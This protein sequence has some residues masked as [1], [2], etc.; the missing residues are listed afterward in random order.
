MNRLKAMNGRH[1][2]NK[3][4]KPLNTPHQPPEPGSGPSAGSSSSPNSGL[5]DGVSQPQ[6]AVHPAA[7]TSSPPVPQPSRV[8][9]VGGGENTRAAVLE[10]L[11]LLTAAPPSRLSAGGANSVSPSP[12]ALDCYPTVR[13]AMEHVAS[14]RP[15]IAL[16][17]LTSFDGLSLRNVR[18]LHALLPDLRILTIAPTVEQ[19]QPLLSLMAGASGCLLKPL[20]VPQLA[21]SIFHAMDGRL[22]L[23]APD[24]RALLNWMHALGSRT[25]RKTLTLQE[26]RVLQLLAQG[27]SY[28]EISA[29][30]GIS[31]HTVHAHAVNAFRKLGAHGRNDAVRKLLRLPPGDLA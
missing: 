14:H 15:A 25:C 16:V 9:L 19:A 24:E 4:Q 8:A 12:F 2:S 13:L 29:H 21:R 10:A 1:S 22:A 5:A 3:N 27:L 23:S 6:P 17:E 11:R 30:L 28:K 7:P 26:E 20:A 18:K 31:G